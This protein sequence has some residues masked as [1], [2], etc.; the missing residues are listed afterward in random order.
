MV[1]GSKLA[2]RLYALLRLFPDGL[3]VNESARRLG[4]S[5][6]SISRISE[7][8]RFALDAKELRGGASGDKILI[9]LLSLKNPNV[10][11]ETIMKLRDTI[12]EVEN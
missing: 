10:S 8:Y 11:F 3:T 12:S 7:R 6:S 4:C 2:R 5:P 9:K 1:D